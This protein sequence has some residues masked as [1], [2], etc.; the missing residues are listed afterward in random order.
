[1]IKKIISITIVCLL[2]IP[3]FSSIPISQAQNSPLL[4]LV[5]STVQIT[6]PSE[7]F[8]LVFKISDVT[9]LWAWKAEVTWDSQYLEMTKNP[10]QGD[11]YQ[12]SDT[13]TQFTSS[14]NKIGSFQ[15]ASDVYGTATANE[16]TLEPVGKSGSGSLVIFT[17]KVLKPVVSTII[18]VNAT[19]LLAPAPPGVGASFSNP[20]VDPYPAVTYATA[21]VSYIPSDGSPV[22]D[23]GSNQTVKQFTSVTLDASQTLP[24]DVAD[25]T[26]TWTFTDNE[27][28]TLT[29]KIVNYTFDWPGIIPVTLTVTNSKGTSTA[30]I[31]ITVVSITPPVP[32]I[33]VAGYSGQTIN[34]AVN[35]NLMFYDQSYDPYNLTLSMDGWNF[36]DGNTSTR[37]NAGHYYS[38]PGTY[39]VS[40]TV[41]N[42]A[43]LN[44]TATKT[45]VVGDGITDA[46]PRSDES[47][48]SSDG[49]STP[50]RPTNQGGQRQNT[51]SLPPIILYPLIFV[52]VFAIGGAAFWL[53][54]KTDTP[55]EQK[56]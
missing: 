24:Q 4:S 32:V 31:G 7:T 11:F 36:G 16:A 1:M 45:I 46:P 15:G 35:Q 12:E 27:S 51:L 28:R 2:L 47:T 19:R 30:I 56:A 42:S 9:N 54:K 10:L 50:D 5:P 21:V 34:V 17:F 55:S 43:D 29:G 13:M 8:T 22:A 37:V 23:A 14:I 38:A 20:P 40:L 52:T 49:D 41:T 44:A 53:R 48:S 18:T 25:Q 33:H 39:I 6:N 3:F 26:Y